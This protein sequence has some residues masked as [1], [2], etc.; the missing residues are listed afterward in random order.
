MKKGISTAVL[1]SALLLLTLAFPCVCQVIPAEGVYFALQD[2]NTAFD[3]FCDI[4]HSVLPFLC[5]IFVDHSD[6][7]DLLSQLF[8]HRL[9]KQ[10]I[11]PVLRQKRLIKVVGQIAICHN[12]LFGTLKIVFRH[13]SQ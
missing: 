11:V 10:H 12:E 3:L 5:M 7:G 6:A 13:T 9:Q 8:Q 1:L 2:S 4:C